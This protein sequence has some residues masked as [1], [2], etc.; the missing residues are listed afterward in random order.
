MLYGHNIK[1]QQ[2]LL[3]RYIKQAK[4]MCVLKQCVLSNKRKTVKLTHLKNDL[5]RTFGC[6]AYL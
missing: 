2:S 5:K 6:N 4:S 1:M 3:H